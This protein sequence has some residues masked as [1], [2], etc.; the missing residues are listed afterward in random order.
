MTIDQLD[1]HRAG[2]GV[3]DWEPGPMGLVMRP[4]DTFWLGSAGT[5]AASEVIL[6]GQ[7]IQVEVRHLARYLVP[8]EASHGPS[9]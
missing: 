9:A 3:A 2:L 4:D 5:L 8:V 1:G 6:T 7:A